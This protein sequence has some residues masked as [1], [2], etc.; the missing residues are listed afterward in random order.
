M[1]RTLKE[2]H[3]KE[4]THTYKVKPHTPCYSATAYRVKDQKVKPTLQG[5]DNSEGEE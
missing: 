4:E 5:K 2:A 3:A 1:Y